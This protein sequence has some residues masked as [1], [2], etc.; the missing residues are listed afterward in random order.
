MKPDQRETGWD[1]S[2]WRHHPGN[3]TNRVG[4]QYV[5]RC[6]KQQVAYMT[7]TTWT[8][9]SVESKCPQ[10]EDVVTRL[11]QAKKFTIVDT[12]DGFWKKRLDIESSYK[13]TFNTPFGR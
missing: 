11:S 13:T 3:W 10:V 9:V 8:K 4:L 7:L 12:K 5:G 6:Q 2:L 1:G